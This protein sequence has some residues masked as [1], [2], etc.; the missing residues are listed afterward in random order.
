MTKPTKI[1]SISSFFEISN[2]EYRVFDMGRNIRQLSKQHFKQIEEQQEQYPFPFQQQAWLGILFWHPKTKTEPVIWF[3]RL[4]IDEVGLLKLEARDSFIQQIIEQVGEKIKQDSDQNLALGK[5]EDSP[6]AFKPNQ[7]KMAMFNALAN[8]E[9]KHPASKYYESTTEYLEGQLG[10]D[11]WSFL[12]LQ[13][14]ADVIVRLDDQQV[15]ESL[16]T[17]IPL[18]P[19]PPLST[20][21]QMLEHLKIP[22]ELSTVILTRLNNELNNNSANPLLVASFIRALSSAQVT[23]HRDEAILMAI[24]AEGSQNIEILAAIASRAWE[25]LKNKILLKE[26]LEALAL[27][28]QASFDGILLNIMT[29]P[30]V[31]TIILNELRSSDRSK[32][33]ERKT[34]GFMKH[35]R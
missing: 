13:G 12:G 27:Q 32:Q 19:E 17:S 14:I 6:F 15:L 23:E 24:K 35:F 31:Q 22:E 7:D 30:T 29:I 28:E 11:Q 21:C 9:L 4:P 34:G 33:L 3:I 18:I 10:Y 16:I 5:V 8:H 25:A 1:D 20:F 2:Y 26:F